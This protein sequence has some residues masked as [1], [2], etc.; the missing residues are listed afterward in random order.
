MTSSVTVAWRWH[1]LGLLLMALL[2]PLL[3][4]WWLG[5]QEALDAIGAFPGTLLTL[6]VVTA[7]LCWNLNAA[8][9]QLLLSGRA[10]RLGQH[11]ALAIEMAAKFAL[12][13]T[14]G[15]TGGAA[16]F[17]VLLARRGYPPARASAI[18]LVDQCCDLLFFALM[19]TLLVAATLSG[20]IDWPYRVLIGTALLAVGLLLI[21]LGLILLWLPRLLRS[22]PWLTRPGRRRRRQVA[23]QLL[24]GR[25]T[26]I[27]TLRLPPRILAAIFGLCC[28]HWLLRYSLLY[29]AVIGISGQ[30]DALAD[31]AWTFMVQMLAMAASQF[32]ILPGGAGAAEISVGAMLMPLMKPEQAAAAVVIWRLVS[33]H[34]YLVAGAPLFLMAT[35]GLIRQTSP[36]RS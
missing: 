17:V 5:G 10:G 6:M 9:W 29:L 26:L 14:P 7:V 33:Y 32:S 21:G 13:A 19:L 8:R 20:M 31:W 34:L 18:Y 35:Y 11:G 30:G 4:S 24:S 28:L 27:A 1:H 12:C 3:V 16:T 23:R 22:R 2:A 25:R 15:G 36:E